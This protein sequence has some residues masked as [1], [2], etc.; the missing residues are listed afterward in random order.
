MSRIS[1][2]SQEILEI[3]QKGILDGTVQDMA[4]TY[5]SEHLPGRD[6]MIKVRNQMIYSL[7]DKSP[8]KNTII[9]KNKNL[10]FPKREPT[11]SG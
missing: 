1:P 5:F 11:G 2:I 8:N 6:L 7:Y 10:Y 4:G 9:G 3:N